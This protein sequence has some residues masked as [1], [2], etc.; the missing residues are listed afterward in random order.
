MRIIPTALAA[1][2]IAATAITA[3]AAAAAPAPTTPTPLAHSITAVTKHPVPGEEEAL[4]TIRLKARPMWCVTFPLHVRA[5]DPL[6]MEPC[7]RHDPHQVWEMLRFHALGQIYI[8]GTNLAIGYRGALDVARV[9][10]NSGHDPQ[11]RWIVNFS[12]VSGGELIGVRKGPQ[13]WLTAP[14]RLRVGI[15]IYV[16]NWSVSARGLA[17]SQTWILPPWH[18]I[19]P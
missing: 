19:V 2:F 10:D 5:N 18:R 4:G 9:V 16:L 1:A 12:P 3:T 7:S 14:P 11:A 6:L 17:Q 15:K 13:K 8:P